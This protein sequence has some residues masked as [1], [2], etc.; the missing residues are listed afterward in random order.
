MSEANK[1]SY[2]G[3]IIGIL[4]QHW[5]DNRV[6]NVVC[7]GH[8]VPAGYFA[9]PMVDTLNAYPHLLH[10]G[11]KHRFPFAVINVIVTAVGGENSASGAERFEAEVLNHRP[12]VLTIDYGFND[13]RLGL[14]RAEVA[15]RAMIERAL[16]QD[17]K[18]L[19]LTPTADV[20]QRADAD[21]DERRELL[22]HAA[23]IRALAQGYGVGLVDSLAAFER[24]CASGGDLSD[25]LAWSN[26]P[27]RAGHELVARELLRWFPIL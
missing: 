9:T 19:L 8:S 16:K 3:K 26:H 21:P 5:P 24:Y 6:V 15:W 11:L 10:R 17:V 12:D 18:L 13:R 27:N 7:H 25:L 1:A 20:T 22:Q 4:N 2:L 14:A 23:Q